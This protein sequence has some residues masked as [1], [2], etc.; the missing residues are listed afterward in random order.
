MITTTAHVLPGAYV[1]DPSVIV[2]LTYRVIRSSDDFPL[3]M[4]GA[5]VAY[6]ITDGQHVI[7]G[8]D[9]HA[10]MGFRSTPDDIVRALCSFLANDYEHATYTGWPHSEPCAEFGAQCPSLRP[11]YL[12]TCP[13]FRRTSVAAP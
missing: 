6:R 2:T 8:A 1:G 13:E 3:A 10:P 7:E 9:L 12:G 5:I 4:P 11:E